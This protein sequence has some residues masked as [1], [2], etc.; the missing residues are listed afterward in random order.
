MSPVKN[1]TKT[2]PAEPTT[3][4]KVQFN[5]SNQRISEIES[6]DEFDEKDEKSQDQSGALVPGERLRSGCEFQNRR[7]S[8]YTIEEEAVV[9]AQGK[10]RLKWTKILFI[11]IALFL[12]GICISISW[13]FPK[14]W[15]ICKC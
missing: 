10:K 15:Y 3:P 11:P 13:A 12:N 7:K 9:R 5:D 2:N 14:Y 6:D 8:K 1:D 4:S